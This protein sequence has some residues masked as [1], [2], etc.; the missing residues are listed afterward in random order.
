MNDSFEI[1]VEYKL[2]S[3]SFNARLIQFGY[4]HKILVSV[5]GREIFFEPDE[6]GHYRATV[7][8]T[9]SN[10]TTKDIDIQLLKAIAET[11]ESIVK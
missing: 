4:T 5:F 10:E 1:D 9:E 8:F 7:E 11:I 2:R 6:E 3:T